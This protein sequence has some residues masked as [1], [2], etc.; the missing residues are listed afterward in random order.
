MTDGRAGEDSE[1]ANLFCG[2]AGVSCL[3]AE[4][5]VPQ[6]VALVEHMIPDGHVDDDR[7]QDACPDRQVVGENAQLIVRIIDPAP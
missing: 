5:E 7:Q 1:N 2:A 6:L 3:V 4:G